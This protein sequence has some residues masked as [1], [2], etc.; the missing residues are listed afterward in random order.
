MADIAVSSK[1]NLDE[2]DEEN[3]PTESEELIA[4]RNMKQ[5]LFFFA[6]SGSDYWVTFSA[7]VRSLFLEHVTY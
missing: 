6:A 2:E 1:A 5:S 4:K 3:E 7:N